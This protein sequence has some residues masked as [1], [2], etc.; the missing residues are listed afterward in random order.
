MKPNP[1]LPVRATED[2]ECMYLQA[3]PV[4]RPPHGGLKSKH[5]D[6]YGVTGAQRAFPRRIKNNKQQNPTRQT[7]SVKA[8]CHG[9]NRGRG[10]SSEES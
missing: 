5:G 3:E 10:R 9:T 7:R 6:R 2:A 4:F 8:Y 1:A